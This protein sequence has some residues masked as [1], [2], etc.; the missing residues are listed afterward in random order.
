MTADQ[1]LEVI[2]ESVAEL[3]ETLPADGQLACKPETALFGPGSTIDSI[4]L[5]GLILDLEQRLAKRL[6]LTVRL[7]DER[8]MSQTKSPYRTVRSLLDF[9]TEAAQRPPLPKAV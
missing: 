7:T 5:V 4:A 6:G 1:V 8:A 2:Y 9:I 3:N